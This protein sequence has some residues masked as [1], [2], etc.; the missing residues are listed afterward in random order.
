MKI[1]GAVCG[2][3]IGSPYEWNNIKT[4][5]FPL[6]ISE[7]NFTDDT[8]LTVAVADALLNGK[9]LSLTLWEYGNAYPN[10][11]YGL[12]FSSWLCSH[13]RK[14]YNSFGNGSAMRVSPVAYAYGT[15]EEVLKA[16]KESAEVTHSH[17]EGIKG[18][19]AVAAAIFMALHGSTKE[20][21]KEYITKTFRYNL[22]KTMDEIR[23]NYTFSETLS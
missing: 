2:D 4:S 17:R 6:F 23:T 18:A 16:A 9:D 3:I 8:V 15:L 12:G 11:G 13:E 1:F 19:Q 5:S 7:S 10:C 21:I 14:P 20:E 22:E